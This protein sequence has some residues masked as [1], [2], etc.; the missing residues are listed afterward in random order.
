MNKQLLTWALFTALGV[1]AA[2]AQD[3]GFYAGGSLGRS[4]FQDFNGRDI[5]AQLGPAYTSSTSTDDS[6]TGWKL[7]AGYQIMPYLAVEGAYTNFGDA[8]AR[9]LITAAPP[10]TP[11]PLTLHTNV[12]ADAW[13]VSALGIL[14]LPYNFSVFARAGV[15]FWDYEVSSSALGI[16]A[17]ASDD[18]TDWVYGVGAMYRFAPNLSARAEWERY[19]FDNDDVDLLSAGIAWHF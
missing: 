14:P 6:D 8:T 12:E 3:T 5:D 1:G 7:F 18:G 17:S 13:S 16:A 2:Q 9:T 15:N 4:E 10:P 19:D 11:V